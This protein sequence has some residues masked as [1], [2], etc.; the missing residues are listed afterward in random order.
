MARLCRPA[1]PQFPHHLVDDRIA[2]RDRDRV[3]AGV[4]LELGEDMPYVAL[5]R[6]LA[7]EEL[8]RDVARSTCRRPAAGGSG[9]RAASADPGCRARGTSASEPDRRSPRRPRPSRSRG[10][11]S[12]SSPPSGGSRARP[13]RAPVRAGFAPQK[14]VKRRTFVP[15]RRS[16]S[17]FVASRPSMPGMRMSITTTSGR[18]RSAREIALSPSDASP[19]TRMCGARESDRRSPS[20]TISWSSAM[21][22]VISAGIRCFR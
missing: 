8:G 14:A 2:N 18:R 15:G 3:R 4:G 13:I 11:A 22:Q 7:D 9:A 10:R 20:R 6:L 21:R 16:S 12:R 1:A 5:H 17:S 19:T